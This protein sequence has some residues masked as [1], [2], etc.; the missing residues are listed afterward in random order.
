MFSVCSLLNNYAIK[1][2][3]SEKA[4]KANLSRTYVLVYRCFC[5]AFGQD[6]TATIWKNFVIGN[7]Q[8]F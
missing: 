6:Q 2:G 5:V 1:F 8:C 3:K 4:T 7:K